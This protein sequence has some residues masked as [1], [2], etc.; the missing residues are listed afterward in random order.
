MKLTFILIPGFQAVCN[1]STTT[2]VTCLTQQTIEIGEIRYINTVDP[3]EVPQMLD[4]E[5]DYSY[6]L[7][8]A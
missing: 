8:Y 4:R 5:S 7:T 2:F 6:A 1:P 3:T